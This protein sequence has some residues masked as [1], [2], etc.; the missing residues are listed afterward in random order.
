M[1][2][3]STIPSVTAS[4]KPAVSPI[5]GLIEGGATGVGFSTQQA[6]DGQAMTHER[7]LTLLK[8]AGWQC[9]KAGETSDPTGSAWTK[10]GALDKRGHNEGWKQNCG[11]PVGGCGRSQP[12]FAA[13]IS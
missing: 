3:W 7:F 4:A 6:S 1:T 11:P 2:D 13:S 12:S 9:L 10:A 8:D 5:A